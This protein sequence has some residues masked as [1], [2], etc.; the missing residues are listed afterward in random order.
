M[1]HFF[2]HLHD[3]AAGQADDGFEVLG[4]DGAIQRY[5]RSA[6]DMIVETTDPDEVQ[7]EVERGW[8]ILDEREVSSGGREP[9]GEDLIVGIEGLRVGGLLGYERAETI[10]R[11]TI[12]ILAEGADGRAE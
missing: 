7:R 6:F 4:P 11:Y 3:D 10:T 5:P 12:G 8:V 9:S 2:H 1:G